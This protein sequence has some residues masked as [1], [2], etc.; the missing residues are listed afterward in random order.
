[1][2][3]VRGSFMAHGSSGWN[4]FEQIEVAPQGRLG[5]TCNDE[6]CSDWAIRQPR[7]FAEFRYHRDCFF[8]PQGHVAPS[9][10]ERA[11][12]QAKDKLLVEEPDGIF[13]REWWHS[14][15]NRLCM[16]SIRVGYLHIGTK[17]A[18][19]DNELRTS[20]SSESR[21]SYLYRARLRESS[22]VSS[23]CG[24]IDPNT[25][26][27]TDGGEDLIKRLGLSATTAES[28]MLYRYINIREDPGSISL[29]V[30]T[31]MIVEFIEAECVSR[32][33]ADRNQLRP[34][35]R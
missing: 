6:G 23:T 4:E 5:I 32:S 2:S 20:A 3:D 22:S 35:A 1:M 29:V 34:P 7:E 15:P 24:A 26:V 21:E 18:A 28:R 11:K 14:S 9:R 8:C 30:P 13:D 25:Y 17:A 33:F 16:S 19:I 10:L 12:L 27:E 31:S